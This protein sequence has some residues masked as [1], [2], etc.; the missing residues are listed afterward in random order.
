MQGQCST[1]DGVGGRHKGGA[2]NGGGGDGGGKDGGGGGCRQRGKAWGNAR[3]K[4]SR[5]VPSAQ[6]LWPKIV[7]F[8][9]QSSGFAHLQ[10]AHA[11]HPARFVHR[12]VG[13]ALGGAAA[14]NRARIV[15]ELGVLAAEQG[16]ERRPALKSL[17]PW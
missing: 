11:H 10:I 2:R 13:E 16:L 12:K 14:Q 3:V 9:M 17:P 6:V 5:P 4:I 8:S 7:S 1:G 15:V